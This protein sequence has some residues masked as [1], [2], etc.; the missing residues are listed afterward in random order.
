[1]A[2]VFPVGLR[3]PGEAMQLAGENQGEIHLVLAD[4]V[5]P[6]MNGRELIDRL[7]S[8]RP[9]VKYLFMSGYTADVVIHRGV[10]EREVN[11]IQ[12]PFS[13]KDIAVKVREVLDA[14]GKS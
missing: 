9:G 13:L 10:S 6:K 11:F 12:K 8:N 2:R 7:G 1:M 3:Y 14:K 5:M 4:V